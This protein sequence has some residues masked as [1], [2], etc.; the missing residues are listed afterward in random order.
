MQS[1]RSVAERNR[2]SII[3]RLAPEVRLLGHAGLC[4][5]KSVPKGRLKVAQDAILG[6]CNNEEKSR[7]GRLRISQ[8]AILGRC[9]NEEKSRRG[10]LKV[11]QDAILGRCNNEEKSRRDG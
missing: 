2:T 3:G 9:N 11:A 10:R 4:R 8:D 6:R 5:L 1:S 7:R